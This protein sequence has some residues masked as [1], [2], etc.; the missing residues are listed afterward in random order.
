ME[1]SPEIFEVQKEMELSLSAAMVTKSWYLAIVSF[2]N[3]FTD[4][5]PDLWYG[6][7]V[8]LPVVSWVM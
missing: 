2:C 7:T 4:Y 1:C 6:K 8:M 3:I 5:T